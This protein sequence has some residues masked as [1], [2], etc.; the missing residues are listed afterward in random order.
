MATLGQVTAE[1]VK[2]N[3]KSNL[4]ENSSTLK[5]NLKSKSDN[6][7]GYKSKKVSGFL[8]NLCSMGSNPAVDLINV[9]KTVENPSS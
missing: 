7:Q 1:K 8:N 4:K 2:I 9:G 6:C 3:S 5:G